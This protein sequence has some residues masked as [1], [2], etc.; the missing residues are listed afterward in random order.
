MCTCICRECVHL[1][2]KQGEVLTTG[3]HEFLIVKRGPT[4]VMMEP[5]LYFLHVGLG[6]RQSFI[7]I[8]IYIII[9]IINR[10]T[11]AALL[12]QLV[13]HVLWCVWPGAVSK[14]PFGQ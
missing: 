9:I 2:I 6:S 14:R 5:L 4:F 8:I 1:Y 10:S 11:V 12:L 13:G 3:V 7:I